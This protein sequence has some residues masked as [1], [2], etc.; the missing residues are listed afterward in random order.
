MKYSSQKPNILMVCGSLN[1]TTMLHQI[2]RY[3]DGCSCYFTPF[4]ADGLLGILMRLGF[5]DFT[6]L[7]GAHRRATEA[8]LN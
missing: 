4:Y 2:S 1:Q 3:M 5:L 6:I 7:G 8:Y